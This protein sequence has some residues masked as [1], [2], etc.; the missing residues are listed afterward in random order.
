LRRL[1]RALARARVGDNCKVVAQLE[2][3]R[4]IWPRA[5]HLRSTSKRLA[6]AGRMQIIRVAAPILV[7]S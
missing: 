7:P 6:A 1:R 2:P 4:V 3:C 5:W